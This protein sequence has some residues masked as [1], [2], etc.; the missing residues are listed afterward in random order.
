MYKS[1]IFIDL[2]GTLIYEI[3]PGRFYIPPELPQTLYRLKESYYLPVV[4]TARQPKFVEKHLSALFSTGIYYNG[5]F[6]QHQ[7]TPIINIPLSP[8]EIY[9]TVNYWSKYG[10]SL[11][12]QG[13]QHGYCY[14]ISEKHYRTLNDI[15]GITD[16]IHP[17][18]CMQQE[19]VYAIDMF[20]EDSFQFYSC[21][22]GIAF[23]YVLDYHQGDWTGSLSGINTS[24]GE[25]AMQLCQALQIPPEN[26]YAFG[27]SNNDLSL[28]E[29]VGYSI[30]V[31]NASQDLIK[32][33]NDV[34]D[35]CKDNGVVNALTT[36]L[37]G[38]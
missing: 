29:V 1:I 8:E 33:A 14:N 22:A 30:A 37:N 4:C 6:V 27:D 25:A 16:Y 26:C 38:G 19:P 35:H 15:Y 36:L 21:K 13:N 32:I 17:Y 11:I 5:A 31:K 23:P 24:K 9:H 7:K 28:F 2:D 34:T 18:Y 20:F 12:F 10:G 3:S